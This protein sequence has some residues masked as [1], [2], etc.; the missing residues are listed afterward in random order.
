LVKYKTAL[1]TKSFSD[2]ERVKVQNNANPAFILRNYLL[3]DAIKK[4]EAGDY[5]QVEVLL[6]RSKKPFEGDSNHPELEGAV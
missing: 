4:A 2:E 6:N 3:E 1:A 5:S